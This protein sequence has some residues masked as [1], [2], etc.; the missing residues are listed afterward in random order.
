[1]KKV[2]CGFTFLIMAF[3]CGNQFT[4]STKVPLKPEDVPFCTLV[5]NA[6]R[7]NGHTI[8]V[9]AILAVGPEQAVLYDTDCCCEDVSTWVDFNDAFEKSS[10]GMWQQLNKVLAAN[11]RAYVVYV[12]RFDGPKKFNPPQGMNPNLAALLRKANSRYGHL[13]GYRFQFVPI[14]LERVQPVP[15]EV[16]WFQSNRHEAGQCNGN[17][18]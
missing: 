15:S 5:H 17:R 4:A 6:E 13:N 8:R 7:Y 18:K 3:L 1:M 11:H 9:K 2:V 14:R 10:P 12:G 16:P